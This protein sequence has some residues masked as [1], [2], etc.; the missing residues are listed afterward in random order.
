VLV[1]RPLPLTSFVW[2]SAFIVARAFHQAFKGESPEVRRIAQKQLLG[3]YGMA[4]AF[5][6]VKGLPFFGLAETIAQM[7]NALFGDDDEPFNFDEEM[8]DFF[9]ELIY[10]GLYKLPDQSRDSQPHRSGSRPDLP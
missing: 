6:G 3:M 5:A 2:N 9:G 10:K 4:G 8:R 7:L 1:V